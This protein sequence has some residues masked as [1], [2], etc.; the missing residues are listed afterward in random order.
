LAD[1][2]SFAMAHKCGGLRTSVYQACGDPSIFSTNDSR[3][4]IGPIRFA[5]EAIAIIII[6]RKQEYMTQSTEKISPSHSEEHMLGHGFYNKHSHEQARANTYA[7]PLIVE[8]INRID[9]AQI[10][11]EFRIADYGSAQGQNSLLPM[12]TAIAQTRARAAKP[13]GTAIPIDV[14]HT[15]LPTNDWSTL[16]QTVLFSPDSYL[17]GETDVF[18]FASGTSIYQ[19]IFPPA[20]IALGYS[21]I[22]EHW[23]SRK[24]CN[25]P[26][27]IWSARATGEVHNT[28]AAQART[29]WHAFLQYRALEMQPSAQLLIIGSGANAEGNSGA[30]GLIDLAN[31]ILQQL[32]KD[33]TLY[34][35][36]YEEM[37]I[38][39]YY[40]IAEEWTEPFMPNSTS[41]P[42]A[43]L[44]LDHFEE[45]TLPDVYLEQFQQDGNA[46]AF[47]EAYS[48]F[49][50]AAYEPCLFVNLNDKRTAESRQQVIDLFSQR[51]QSALAQ[52]PAKYSCRWILDLMLI[53]K[54]QK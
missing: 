1:E 46:Q 49:F 8:A 19:Q 11:G 43:D 41:V 3:T 42:A 45:V 52:D 21:A 38:P 36:E 18:C 34:P 10:G 31:Q 16:F 51:L 50:K 33:G 28:W 2:I 37:A 39:T 30:E 54:K 40:R 27:E 6:F 35:T 9:L 29:D 7:L 20:H 53:S 23:L 5:C 48:G 13:S 24:P 22:T 47:A 44:S 25:I 32:V 26:N 17:A 15:D 14:T 4:R 12:K